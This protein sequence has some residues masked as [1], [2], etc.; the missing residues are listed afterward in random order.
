MDHLVIDT[1]AG[2][3][4]FAGRLWSDRPRPALLVVAGAFPDPGQHHEIVDWFPDAS[5]LVANLPGMGGMP[6][7]AADA[8]G[9]S[10]GLAEAMRTVLG[11]RPL[12]LCGVSA[13]GL[14]TLPLQAANIRRKVMIEPFLTTGDLWPFLAYAR[15]LLQLNPGHAGLRR[16][17]WTM[18]GFGETTAET[19]D[20]RHLVD[21]IQVP[22]DVVVGGMPLMPQRAEPYFPSLASAGDRAVFAA[23]P[24]VTLYEGPPAAGHGVW[25]DPEANALIRRLLA[26]NLESLAAT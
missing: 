9:L 25:A 14:V 6:W 22:T 8:P 12:V 11:D 20:Y 24:L 1:S 10:A 23:H 17:L 4:G 13:S 3:I 16:Y 5:V 18:F 26:E 7:S 19:R 2:S 15:N 21:S